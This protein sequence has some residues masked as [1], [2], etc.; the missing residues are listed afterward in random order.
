VANIKHYANANG[1]G[2][3]FVVCDSR[4]GQVIQARHTLASAIE[5]ATS[6]ASFAGA[7]SLA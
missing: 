4:T 3:L 1:K 5:L 6:V 2:P 7:A